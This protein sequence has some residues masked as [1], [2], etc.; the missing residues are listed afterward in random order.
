MKKSKAKIKL[1]DK[2]PLTLRWSTEDKGYIVTTFIPSFSTFGKTRKQA[3]K[4]AE[5]ALEL[6][7][8]V[9]KELYK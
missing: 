2:Y 9:E 1:G 7:L 6:F 8:K 5:I 3:L 4:E